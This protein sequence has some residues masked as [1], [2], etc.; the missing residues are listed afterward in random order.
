MTINH[1][2]HAGKRTFLLGVW[3]T[4][5]NRSRNK[6]SLAGPEVEVNRLNLRFSNTTDGFPRLVPGS[7]EEKDENELEKIFDTSTGASIGAI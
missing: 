3:S 6:R 4:T 2:K 5:R 1:S 7:Y